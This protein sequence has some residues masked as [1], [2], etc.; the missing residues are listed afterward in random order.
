MTPRALAASLAASLAVAANAMAA[1]AP[2]TETA[3]L[4]SQYTD[5][6]G[7]KANAEALVTGLRNGSPITI[8][9]SGADHTVSIAGFT[10]SAPMSYS[11]VASALAGAHRSLTRMGISR[12]TAEQIQAALIGGEVMLPSGAAAQMRGAVAARGAGP[13]QVAGR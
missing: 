3:R 9:T 6:V 8:V 1:S 12:P 7:G 13:S 10:P 11:A 2:A 4:T 5:W